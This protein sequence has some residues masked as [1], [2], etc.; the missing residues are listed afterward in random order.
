MVE[1][2]QMNLKM[3]FI[4]LVFERRK[5]FWWMVNISSFCLQLECNALPKI[6]P[7]ACRVELAMKLAKLKSHASEHGDVLKTLAHTS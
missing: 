5:I 1:K 4:K 2:D 6:S 3:G 7:R